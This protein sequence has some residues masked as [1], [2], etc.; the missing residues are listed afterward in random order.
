MRLRR[1]SGIRP[2]ASFAARR[3]A[4]GLLCG[5]RQAALADNLFQAFSG[6]MFMMTEVG[7]IFIMTE[8]P[9]ML[10]P[11]RDLA[12]ADRRQCLII[13]SITRSSLPRSAKPS[14]GEG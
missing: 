7:P 12:R 10:G 6:P 3:Q 5:K 8:A 9:T 4:P 2:L 13:M 11:R 1:Y 14:G